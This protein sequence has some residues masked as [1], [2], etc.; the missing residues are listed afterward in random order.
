MARWYAKLQDYDYA[1]K[2]VQGKTNSAADALS[3]P[4]GEEKDRHPENMTIIAPEM[5]I[6]GAFIKTETL[7][8]I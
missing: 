3:R 1:I 4:N 2:H 8:K 7:T 6:K 5:F